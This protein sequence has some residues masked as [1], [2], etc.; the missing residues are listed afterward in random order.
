MVNLFWC[1][2]SETYGSHQ[3]ESGIKKFAD[4]TQLGEWLWEQSKESVMALPGRAGQDAAQETGD[5]AGP[6]DPALAAMGG[7]G[8]GA[9]SVVELVAALGAAGVVEHPP[10]R[11]R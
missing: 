1:V 3:Q 11:P 10:G 5:V 2:L 6:V 8:A 7:A 4:Q 9:R